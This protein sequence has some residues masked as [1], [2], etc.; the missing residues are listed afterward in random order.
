MIRIKISTVCLLLLF[1]KLTYAQ[2]SSDTIK[3][4]NEFSRVMSFSKQPYVYF[5][6]I[7]KVNAIPVLQE[8]DSMSLNGIFYKN[9][10]D[11]YYSTGQDEVYLQDSF[12]I[13][14][15]QKRKSIWISK[16]DVASKEKLNVLPVS[17]SQLKEIFSK[18]YIV[19]KTKLNDLISMLDFETKQKSG[20]TAITT[21]I[22]L[23]YLIKD[24]SPVSME[25][26]MQI[27]QPATEELLSALK[28]ENIDDTRLVQTIGATKYLI[29]SQSINIA[30]DNINSTKEKAIAMP[31]WKEVLDYREA[32][33]EFIARELYKD[34]EVTKT[35]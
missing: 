13:Q 24:F 20:S 18:K 9:Q 29:R 1:G 12:M 11:V 2:T 34:Y 3:M 28:I 22:R 14:I 17:N 33:H 25:V 6:T 21:N 30:F 15:N 8:Q 26:N 16:V 32:T 5:T 7:I 27:R 10:S 23:E 19:N 31:S 35:F 4:V